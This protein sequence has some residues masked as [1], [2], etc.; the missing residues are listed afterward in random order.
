MSIISKR[1]DGLYDIRVNETGMTADAVSELGVQ[2]SGA[3]QKFSEQ[4][5]GG[6]IQMYHYQPSDEG[7]PDEQ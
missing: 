2:I 5:Q 4:I 7:E 6:C 1:Q 3:P